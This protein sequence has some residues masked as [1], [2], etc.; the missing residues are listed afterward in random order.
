M[1]GDIFY[2]LFNMSIVASLS[3]AVILLLRRVRRIPRRLIATLV[4]IAQCAAGLGS[5]L[6]NTISGKLFDAA[7]GSFRLAPDGATFALAKDKIATAFAQS[8]G[9]QI[10]AGA[11]AADIADIA[12]NLE[13]GRRYSG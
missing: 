6:I 1:L 3:G 8:A 11:G 9:V 13:N 2:W 10:P 4:G 7:A 5:F 12:A